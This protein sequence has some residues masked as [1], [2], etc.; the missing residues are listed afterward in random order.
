MASHPSTPPLSPPCPAV[1]AERRAAEGRPA[2]RPQPAGG[3]RLLLLLRGVPGGAPV[4]TTQL[5]EP[6]GRPAHRLA[7]EAPQQVGQEAALRWEGRGMH[8]FG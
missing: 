1:P 7:R 3:V 5:P 2:H 4:Y 8:M 6:G